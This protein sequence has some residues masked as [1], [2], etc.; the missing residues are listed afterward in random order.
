MRR[1]CKV[2]A[3]TLLFVVSAV[4]GCGER[5]LTEGLVVDS[6]KS[7]EVGP[8]QL[9]TVGADESL[10]DIAVDESGVYF[11]VAWYPD[12]LPGGPPGSDTAGAIR[13]VPREGGDTAE[14]WRGQ[15]AAYAVG[16]GTTAIY[17]MTYEYASAG[18]AGYVRSVPRIGG[19]ARTLGTWSSHGSTIGLAVDRDTVYWGHSAGSGGTLNRT[20]GLDSTTTALIPDVSAPVGSK[21]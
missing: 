15:G 19:P 12:P 5:A 20:D 10:S 21:L 8:V 14:L 4:V 17:F 6:G 9:A 16:A 13:R 7:S 11:S 2:P 18:R 1:C 3:S